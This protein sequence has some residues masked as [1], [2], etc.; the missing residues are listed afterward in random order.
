VKLPIPVIGSV[1]FLA[2]QCCFPTLASAQTLGTPQ[3]TDSSLAGCAGSYFVTWSAVS[4]ATSYDIWVDRPDTSGY[5]L[6]KITTDTTVEVHAAQGSL[7]SGINLFEVSACDAS[8]CGALSN[9]IGLD[10]YSG[11]P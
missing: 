6:S 2:L 7:P 1:A 4:G 9:P 5:V 10:W 11:C 8:G 3:F